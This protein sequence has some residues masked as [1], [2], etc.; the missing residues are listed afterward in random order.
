MDNQLVPEKHQLDDDEED[1][2]LPAAAAAVGGNGSSSMVYREEDQRGESSSF[3]PQRPAAIDEASIKAADVLCGRG[4][5]SFNHGTSIDASAGKGKVRIR[6]FH[7]LGGIIQT[8][9]PCMCIRLRV[10]CRNIKKHRVKM[11]P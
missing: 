4:K 11:R 2:K 8:R 7:E 10:P 3:S 1:S 5:E 6:C 9:L